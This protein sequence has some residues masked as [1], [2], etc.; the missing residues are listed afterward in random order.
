MLNKKITAI[1]N[2]RTLTIWAKSTSN[3]KNKKRYAMPSLKSPLSI[4][5]VS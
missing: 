4:A 2:L 1:F 3:K 5:E